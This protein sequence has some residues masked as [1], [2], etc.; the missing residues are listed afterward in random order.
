[1]PCEAALRIHKAPNIFLYITSLLQWFSILGVQKKHLRKLGNMQIPRPPS[2]LF[3][4]NRAG[5]GPMSGQLK[6]GPSLEKY[7][8]KKV[9][10]FSY[11]GNYSREQAKKICR[12]WCMENSW[13]TLP[14]LLTA[15]SIPLS[16]ADQR[17]PEL[18]N[19]NPLTK[20]NQCLKTG[21]FSSE[22]LETL[23]R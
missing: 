18:C 1:M 11:W 17:A 15:F 2:Q 3:W 13:Q 12:V 22:W 8:F 19:V 16:L 10:L 4:S 20:I 7:Y 21:P 6:P 9:C 23:L 5:M 14:R